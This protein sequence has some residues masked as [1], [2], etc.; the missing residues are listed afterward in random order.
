MTNSLEKRILEKI[1]KDDIK[2]RS[3][4]Y[5]VLKN[6][7]SISSFLVSIILG[8]ISFS[9]LFYIF[10]NNKSL[11]TNS[12]NIY[13]LKNAILF[14]LFL[15]V[16]FTFISIWNNKNLKNSYKHHPVVLVLFNILISF[17][18]GL[19]LFFSGVG[20]Q[21]DK[22]SSQHLDFYQKNIKITEI[23]K[24]IFLNKLKEIGITKEILN[25]YPELKSKIELKFNE[26]VLGKT[27]LSEKK[28]LEPDFVCYDGDIFFNDEKGCGCKK[29][30]K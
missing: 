15:L 29:I 20:K 28:C 7:L 9:V 3:K 8:S 24:N 13:Q 25:K 21:T 12:Y 6:S 19:V 5:F 23:K 1:K 10:S 2:P 30:Y 27:Y 18:L 11:I 17:T 16:F 26:K 4:L 14:W 22:I